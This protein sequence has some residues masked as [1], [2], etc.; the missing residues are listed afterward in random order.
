MDVFNLKG[1]RS[2]FLLGCCNFHGWSCYELVKG[3]DD[4]HTK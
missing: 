2:V 1:L 3:A 4:G